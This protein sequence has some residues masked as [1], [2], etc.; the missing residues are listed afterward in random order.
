MGLIA[1]LRRM[2]SFWRLH[3]RCYGFRENKAFGMYM[4]WCPIHQTGETTGYDMA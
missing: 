2:L 1:E 4:L 3:H